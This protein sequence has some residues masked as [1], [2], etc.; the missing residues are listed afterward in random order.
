MTATGVT[1]ENKT[2]N[3]NAGVDP[4]NQIYNG[5]DTSKVLYAQQQNILNQYRSFVYNFAFGPIT[6]QTLSTENPEDINADLRKYGIIN[7]SGK[8]G[9]GLGIN[10]DSSFASTSTD[11]GAVQS[12]VEE[13]NKNSPGSYDM[14]IDNVIIDSTVGAG[15]REAGQSIASNIRFEVFEPYSM[16]G[17]LEAM[18]VSAK[19]AGY[20]D[21][22]KA[23]FCLRIKFQGWRDTADINTPPEDIDFSTRY[24]CVSITECNVDV[25]ESG[26]K[27]HLVTAATN[28]MG[29][30][31]T[32]ILSND[33]KI[34]GNTVGEV[35][36]NFFDAINQMIQSRTEKQTDQKGFDTYELSV[37]KL[38]TVDTPQ[39]TLQAMLY[40]PPTQ[41]HVGDPNYQNSELLSAKINDELK[42]TNV[43]KFGDPAQ[44]KNGYMFSNVPGATT[45]NS[46]ASPATGGLNPKE[47]TIVFAAGA[48]IHECIAGIIRDSEYTRN[49]LSEENLKKAEQGNQQITYFTVRIET[50]LNNNTY[51][52]TNN[53][54]FANY[55]Y[56]VEPFQIPLT[57]V[58][59][60]R[61]SKLEYKDIKAE[62]KRSYNYIYTGKNEE[63]IKFNLKFDNLYFD[64][65]PALMGNVTDVSSSAG[66]GASP[67]NTVDAKTAENKTDKAE[68]QKSS[69]TTA[70]KESV[71]VNTKSTTEVATQLGQKSGQAQLTPYYQLAKN[72]HE[73]VLNRTALVMA[74]LEILGDPYFLC[75]SGMGKQNLILLSPGFTN[76]GEAPYT[77]GELLISLTFRTPIDFDPAT[78][79]MKFD[80]KLAPYNGLY[81]VTTLVNT[82][83]DGQFTQK[84]TLN[85]LPGQIVGNEQAQPNVLNKTT[86]AKGEQVVKDAAPSTVQKTGIKTPSFDLKNLLS[87]GADYLASGIRLAASGLALL[88][89]VDNLLSSGNTSA[90]A[91]APTTSPAAQAIASDV[92]A[93]A[94]A[95]AQQQNSIQGG[96]YIF[97]YETNPITNNSPASLDVIQS[98]VQ[99]DVRGVSNAVGIDLTSIAGLSPGAQSQLASQLT[100]V[101]STVPNNINIAGLAAAGVALAGITAQT[102]RNIPAS[103]PQTNAAQATNATPT[104]GATAV[105]T[106]AASASP[107]VQALQ[108]G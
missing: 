33:I 78:G 10:P 73:A 58:P 24:F 90:A 97:N 37:P 92:V 68:E 79:F 43:F 105:P 51:D 17:F 1:V 77:Q 46:Q 30:G 27:Y 54:Y 75:T 16:N 20:P 21:F 99:N 69:P 50:S 80:E 98:P 89:A 85:R 6:P 65:I 59:G 38:V 93:T 11:Y 108:K 94:V 86:P 48:S 101:T 7:S 3:T 52:S 82:F 4:S 41:N 47:G 106:T 8:G 29:F 103:Q 91:A 53:K 60:Y 35:L 34:T 74:D 42:S 2:P 13:F 102:I 84:L 107:L 39:D 71:A 15:S 70:P 61:Q 32:N 81:L 64:S 88:S 76:T 66:A 40:S 57:M 45:A 9:Q 67:A 49:L 100:Q 25:G 12:M 18:S 19:A 31:Q 72:L 63:I 83:R 23:S 104:A 22:L 55:R 36:T 87:P 14:F 26:T 96:T 95:T 44:F 56:V 62:V 5:T 28:Q